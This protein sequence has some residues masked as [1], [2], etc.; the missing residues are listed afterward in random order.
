VVPVG[1]E[2]GQ[3]LQV[4]LRKG[5]NFRSREVTPVAFVPLRG[6]H[7]WSSAEWHENEWRL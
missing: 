7:G 4:L 3:Y 6:E 2:Y 1:G 5:N